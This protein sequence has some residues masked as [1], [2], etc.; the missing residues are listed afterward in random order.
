[1]DESADCAQVVAV[2]PPWDEQAGRLLRKAAIDLDRDEQIVRL[3]EQRYGDQGFVASRAGRGGTRLVLAA[4]SDVGL[5]GA[6]LTLCDRLYLDS[7]GNMV[8]DPFDGVHLPTFRERHLKTDA[9][10]CGAFN[11]PLDYWDPTTRAG[12]EEFADW[13][14][15]FRITDYDL[16]AFVRGWGTS[17]PSDRFPALAHPRHPNVTHEFYPQLEFFC[18]LRWIGQW[19]IELADTEVTI[20]H[21]DG[22]GGLETGFDDMSGLDAKR[23]QSRDYEPWIRTYVDVTREAGLPS[24]SWEPAFQRELEQQYWLYSQLTWEPELSWA[25]VARRYVLR[26]ER[27]EDPALAQAYQLSLELNASITDW[28]TRDDEQGV[29]LRVVQPRKRENPPSFLEKLAGLEAILRSI[30]V[31]EPDPGTG[32]PS[33]DLRWSIAKSLARLRSGEGHYGGH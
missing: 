5:R 24:I 2:C 18:W 3:A 14:A 19:L 28:G 31:P 23:S 32:P 1:M 7:Q 20:G 12:V 21:E 16:L 15:S 17:Y 33:F 11:L 10:F 8:A 25:E 22:G 27:R 30:G 26:S 6:L 29:A 4:N 13:L 9:M